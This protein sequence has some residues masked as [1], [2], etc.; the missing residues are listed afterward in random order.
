MRILTQLAP[1]ILLA[2][3]V[4][5][6]DEGGR[7]DEEATDWRSGGKGDGETCDFAQMS[8]QT[9]YDQFAYKLI[10]Y[11]G[12]TSKW[13]RVGLTWDV[14]ATLDNGDRVDLDV[15]FLADNRVI[16]EYG[17]EHRIDSSRSD[18]NNQSVIV[19]RATIDPTTRAITIAGVG[20]GTPITVQ[21]NGG[22]SPGITFTFSSDVRS[23]GLAGDSTV[24]SAGLTSAFVIDPDH[25]DDVPYETTRNWFE[26][27][28][29]SGKIKVIR[30]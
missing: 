4:T 30:K 18:V 12:S 14:Q 5:D 26:E 23:P 6:D 7:T 28:V 2:A 17:E 9:Y 27:D 24:I 1:F 13:Y 10:Q 16:V 19:T 29:A 21:N 20:T 8:A 11:E 22:C 15:Y 25:L 3:C